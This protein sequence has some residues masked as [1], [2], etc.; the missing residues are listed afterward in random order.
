MR[1]LAEELVKRLEEVEQRRIAL[2]FAMRDAEEALISGERRLRRAL[3]GLSLGRWRALVSGQAS[4]RS[5]SAGRDANLAARRRSAVGAAL[6][7]LS[8]TRRASAHRVAEASTAL[9]QAEKAIAALAMPASPGVANGEPP[10]ATPDHQKAL[11]VQARSKEILVMSTRSN[12]KAYQHR[13][14]ELDAEHTRAQERLATAR[15]R[16][17]EVLAAQDRQV[18]EAERELD[19]SVVAM[20]EEIGPELTA[21]LLDIEVVEVK[22][23]VRRA[24]KPSVE[25]PA[26]ASQTNP[27]REASVE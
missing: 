12:V 20:A 24:K 11:R 15:R 26:P 6:R 1:Q 19:K 25:T 2:D 16:R 7:E 27:P 17:D 8:A 10:D 21:N 9:D 3:A 23:L 13:L 14:V 22:Q 5:A 18:R 4:I